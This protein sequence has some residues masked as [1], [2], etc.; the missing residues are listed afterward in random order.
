MPWVDPEALIETL[1]TDARAARAAADLDRATT[2]LTDAAAHSDALATDHPLRAKTRWRLAKVHHDEAR[3]T[4]ALD[5]LTPLLSDEGDPFVGYPQGLD[6]VGAIAEQVWHRLGYRESRV[7]VLWRAVERAHEATADRVRATQARL[8]RLWSTSCRGERDRLSTE[9]E[10][11]SM[12]D[13]RAFAEGPSRH[14]RAPDAVGS[15]PWLQ[16]DAARTALRAATWSGDA[17]L[18]DLA[19]DLFEDAA[20]D[21]DLDRD[22]EIWFLEP[23]ALVRR[24]W[25]RPDPDGYAAMWFDLAGRIDYPRRDYHQRVALAEAARP[26]EITTTHQRYAEAAK[27]ADDGDYGPEWVI[28][29]LAQADAVGEARSMMVRYGVLAFES[30]LSDTSTT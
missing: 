10:D 12:L 20:T 23:I 26:A 30:T 22:N 17:A 14:P 2:A 16:L 19:E 3:P 7:D 6:A 24:R 15:V 8:Q 13:P 27:V 25:Q 29:A 1:L 11:F 18:A 4:Q 9:L 21:A 5:A 28:D